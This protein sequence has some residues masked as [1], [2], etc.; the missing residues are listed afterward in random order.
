MT[1][2]VTPAITADE[3]VAALRGHRDGLPVGTCR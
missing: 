1:D 3:L 2:Q